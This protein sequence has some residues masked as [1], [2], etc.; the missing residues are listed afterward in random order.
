MKRVSMF[1]LPIAALLLLGGIFLAKW[2]KNTISGLNPSPLPMSEGIEIED[3]GR[4]LLKNFGMTD[5]N[6]TGLKNV[7][8]EAGVGVVQWGDDEHKSFTVVANVESMPGTWVQ[9]WI[10]REDGSYMKIGTLREQKAGFI[11]DYTLPEGAAEPKAVVVTREKVNDNTME[12]KLL[13][14]AVSAE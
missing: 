5:E 9:A 7:S 13:E 8:E 1:L 3:N 6:A 10:Q 12:E 14:G 11:L 4:S 2:W